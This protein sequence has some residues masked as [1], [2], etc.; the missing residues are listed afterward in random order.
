MS[1][2]RALYALAFGHAFPRGM[3]AMGFTS[4]LKINAAEDKSYSYICTT[5]HQKWKNNNQWNCFAMAWYTGKNQSIDICH[6]TRHSAT[7]RAL[8][9]ADFKTF[10]QS[11][12]LGGAGKGDTF[13]TLSRNV[14]HILSPVQTFFSRDRNLHSYW[15]SQQGLSTFYIQKSESK[16][17]KS[18]SWFENIC[19]YPLPGHLEREGAAN[20]IRL[21]NFKIFIFIFYQ[22]IYLLGRGGGESLQRKK[23]RAAISINSIQTNVPFLDLAP[24]KTPRCFSSIREGDLINKF[25]GPWRK[26]WGCVK[27]EE[28]M[29][30]NSSLRPHRPLRAPLPLPPPIHPSIHPPKH[31]LIWP[32]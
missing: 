26:R 5:N 23:K 8:I 27:T 2:F 32:V 30:I 3:H 18:W 19:A 4:T 24:R 28:G 22:G 20:T 25:Q 31:L 9:M 1:L 7:D 11:F 17:I 12:F 21:K 29:F 15:L 16:R 6:I 14:L 10:I 13:R